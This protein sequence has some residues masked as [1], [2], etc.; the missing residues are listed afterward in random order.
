MPNGEL[1]KNTPVKKLRQ[2]A[3]IQDLNDKAGEQLAKWRDPK[4]DPQAPGVI[5]MNP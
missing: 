1:G 3:K 5:R 4:N 2:L